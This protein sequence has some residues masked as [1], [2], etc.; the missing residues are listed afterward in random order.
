MKATYDVIVIGVGTMGSSACYQLARRGYSV[1]GIEQFDIVNE[2]SSH[3][4]QSRIIRKAY[5]EHPDYIPLLETAY[6]SWKDFEKTTGSKLYY[7]TGLL[8]AGLSDSAIIKGVRN[9]SINYNINVE[10]I[11]A[12]RVQAQFPQFK[13]PADYEVLLEPD[14]GFLL[15]DVAIKLFA[16]HSIRNGAQL[17]SNEKVLNWTR[18]DTGVTVTTDKGSYTAE[19]LI[20]TAG[21]WVKK[22][23]PNDFE[24]EV[25]RQVIGWVEPEDKAIFA[26]DN[27]PCWVMTAENNEGIYYGF[28]Y[29]EGDHFDGP[30]GLKFG[31]HF[32]GETTDPETMDRNS[33][34]LDLMTLQTI[35][36]KCF[37]KEMKTFIDT[38]TCIY[39]NSPD[40]NF[41]IDF[42]PDYDKDVVI[43]TGFSGHGFKFAPVVGEILANL[44]I[45]GRTTNPIEFL[46]AKRF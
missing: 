33:N 6:E 28:P 45:E 3:S 15:P 7:K 14:A 23:V 41:I 20:I 26:L 44:A 16:E 18:N 21:P 12:S 19:K 25:T 11:K 32:P 4:G 46:S 27:C 2:L 1:L 13:I 5:F 36:R 38:K 42:L 24:L 39:T 35:A 37:S 17:K 30:K 43:A 10:E 9:A 40:E 29:M 8:Y 34:E 31:H 22:I